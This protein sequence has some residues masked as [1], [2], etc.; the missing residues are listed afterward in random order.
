MQRDGMRFYCQIRQMEHPLHKTIT[1]TSDITH[2]TSTYNLNAEEV[3]SEYGDFCDTFCCLD[4]DMPGT[5][6]S[7]TKAK[8]AGDT[9]DE[10]RDYTEEFASWKLHNFLKPLQMCYQLSG[11]PNLLQ[12]Y[13][14]LVTLPVTSCS[15]QRTLSRLRIIKNRLRSTMCDKWMSAL[16]IISAE[17][18]LLAKITND[19]IVDKFGEEW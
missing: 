15:A 7:A 16:M 19:D 17:K 13:W 14:I 3:V 2:L 9:D 1:V 10:E 12:L 6:A 4:V 18:G 5:A 8:D 11:Y